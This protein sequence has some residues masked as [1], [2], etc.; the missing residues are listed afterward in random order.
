MTNLS[1]VSAWLDDELPALL[2]KHD[3]PGAAVAVAVGDDVVDHAAGVLN[4]DT[5][6]EATPDSVFQ[7][8]SITKVWTAS[9]VLQLADEGLVDVDAPVVT[10]VPDLGLADA[11]AARRVTVRQLLSH[12]GGFE[13][14]IFTDTGPGDDC[15]E[16]FVTQLTDVPQLFAPGERFSYNN[17]GYCVLGR[18][19]EVLRGKTYDECLREYL[20]A[21]LGLEHA[22]TGPYDAIRY[23][24][25]IGHVKL[26]PDAPQQV[27][28]VWALPRSN[29]PAGAMLSMRPRDLVAFARMHLS[30]GAAADG[31]QVL[32]ADTVAAMTQ[33]QVELPGFKVLGNAWGLGWE[34]F[35]LDGG[36]VIGHDGNTIGQAGF[37]RISPDSDVAV[38]LLC[39][40]GDSHA[41]YR[42]VVGKILADLAG[43]ELPPL[44]VPPAEPKR[45][46]MSRYV[47]TYSIQVADVVVSEDDEGR[48]WLDQIPKGIFA[49]MG[50]E[51][52]RRELVHF[53]NDTFI[54]L[55]PDRGMHLPHVFVGDDGRGH[56][57]YLHIGRA[58]PW[59]SADATPEPAR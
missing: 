20:F 11:E 58:L 45:V 29:G 42:D 54:P 59:V 10:Y 27:A 7:I 34:I 22:A 50:E 52:E 43:V 17:A 46:D 14:D 18:L 55:E 28:P 6:V 15:V 39:N 5:G 47:G 53:E 33:R 16:K 35:D 23:R 49:E 44:T 36:T 51:P 26:S 25:A 37:L 19:V 9:L 30:Q 2:S 24:A 21:P 1:E 4:T 31:T 13:G 38:A 56:V 48:I 3:V 8:G 32:A 12:T 41:L 57:A 40:G